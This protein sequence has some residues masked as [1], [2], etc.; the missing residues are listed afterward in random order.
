MDDLLPKLLAFPPHPPPSIPLTDTQYDEGIKSHISTVKGMADSKLLLRTSS[1]DG[2]LDLINP[3]INT[4]PYAFTLLAIITAVHKGNKNVDAKGNLWKNMSDFVSNLDPRQIRYLGAELG[5]ITDTIVE[6][7]RSSN[8]IA[9]AVTPVTNSLLNYDPTG[10]MLTSR[11]LLLVKL[12]LN[13]RQFFDAVPVLDKP[14]LY[15]PTQK[16]PKSKLLCNMSSSPSTYITTDN[17]FTKKLKYQEVLEYFLCRGMIYAGLRDWK[18]AFQSLEDAVSFPTKEGAVSKMM[19]D[20]YKKWILVGLLRDG[21]APTLPK[22]T[23]NGA[24]KVYHVIAK[25]YES[26]AQIFE[27]G[28]ASRLKAEADVGTAIWQQDCNLGLVLHVLAAY[29]KTQIR[30]L[31]NIYTKM[32]I[33]EVHSATT[34]AETGFKLP[35]VHATE[36]LVRSMI[37]DGSLHATVSSGSSSPSI[38]TFLPPGTLLS[39]AVF[40]NQLAISTVQVKA[41]TDEIK[42]TDHALT[43]EKDYVKWLQKQKKGKVINIDQG[44]SGPDMDWQND[45]ED[46]MATGY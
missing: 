7:A 31:A 44:I 43:H 46:L 6:Y 35:S 34:S 40:Q 4:V 30:N 9:A 45:D 14:I 10:G 38:L 41:L 13:S 36:T 18:K 25:P 22:V 8:Q 24:A 20:A 27:T 15:F 16:T 39:E 29:Q 1:G 12:S 42:H 17:G 19:I 11:H 32:S 23:G 37:A 5:Q 28:T 26:L 3:S 2:V 33:Q 21:K